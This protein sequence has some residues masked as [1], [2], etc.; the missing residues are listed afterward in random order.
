G[1]RGVPP[2]GGA[3]APGALGRARHE[4]VRA[5]Q[6]VAEL[7]RL[8][9]IGVVPGA[10]VGDRDAFV[11]LAETREDL[12]HLR[13]ALVGA[14]NERE[15]EHVVLALLTDLA[16]VVTRRASQDA[17]EELQGRPLRMLS[18]GGK[19]GLAAVP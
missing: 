1:G 9:E 12:L 10:L 4:R 15:V 7:D 16:G 2:E 8:H 6:Q 3:P 13:E 14:D 18:W 11:P 17:V 5:V 19:V